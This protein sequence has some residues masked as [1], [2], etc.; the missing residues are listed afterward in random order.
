MEIDELS[1]IIFLEVRNSGD[2]LVSFTSISLDSGIVNFEGF[3]TPERWLTGIETAYDGVLVVHNYQS[4]KGPAH[5]GL[6]AIDGR[7]GKTLWS[8]YTLGFDH[9]SVNGPVVYNTQIQPKKIVLADI[10]TGGTVRSYQP[11]IDVDLNN[12]ILSPQVLPAQAL[13]NLN[14]PAGVN[15]YGNTLHYLE[16]NNF[17]IV[18]LHTFLDE[19]LEQLLYI[20]DDK[21]ATVYLDLLQS[22]I[23]KMQPEAF[24]VHNNK[25]IY[26]KNRSALIVLNL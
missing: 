6:T 2:K 19:Q 24:V 10:K 16:H 5:K 20:F 4:E 14:L 22:D 11:A 25:L 8:N 7:T 12:H 23:Q 21:G 17:R 13:N 1:N 26:L 9:L 3:T 15:A 18:S